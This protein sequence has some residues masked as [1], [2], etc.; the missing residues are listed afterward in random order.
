MSAPSESAAQDQQRGQWAAFNAM[1]KRLVLWGKIYL[2]GATGEEL[3]VDGEREPAPK[4]EWLRW[5]EDAAWAIEQRVN[6]LEAKQ[7]IVLRVFYRA[8]WAQDWG[9]IEPDK[10]VEIED[11]LCRRVNV[12]WRKYCAEVQEL[13]R[14]VR[15][16]Q[17]RSIL[18]AAIR[19]LCE[20]TT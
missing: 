15:A 2:Q 13:P 5:Q 9:E 10:R 4:V 12:Q 14:T 1:H 16:Y 8:N 3:G 17:L 20:N 6:E 19:E 11:K 18:D 7:R